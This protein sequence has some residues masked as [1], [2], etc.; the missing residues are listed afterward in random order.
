[1]RN[2]VF[3]R[4]KND[5]LVVEHEGFIQMF[6]PKRGIRMQAPVLIEF[7]LKIKT[8]GGEEGSYTSSS[9]VARGKIQ[10]FDGVI[11]AEASELSRAMVAVA[12]DAKLVVKLKVSQKGG[13]DIHRCT[14]F[15]VEKHG[16]RSFILNL[17]VASVEVM[18]TWS[19]MDIPKSLLGPNCFTH[20]FMASQGV[21]YVDE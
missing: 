8:G 19:T 18:V 12:Q 9:Y 20:E 3:N 14:I 21:D 4:T 6:G 10:L 5:P 7:G 16:S 1:M 17:G 2:Y 13:L 15:L 11:A